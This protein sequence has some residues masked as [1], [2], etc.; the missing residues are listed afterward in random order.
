MITRFSNTTHS[1]I[2]TLDK[3]LKVRN[4]QSNPNFKGIGAVA[5]QAGALGTQFLNF[6]NTSPAIGACFVDFG[7]M[8][9]PRTAVDMSRSLDAGIETGIRESTGTINHASVGIIGLGAGYAV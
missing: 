7:F 4:N 2:K 5:S 9:T 8:V 3:N 6:L 1:N